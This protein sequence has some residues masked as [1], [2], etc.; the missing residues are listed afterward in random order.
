MGR[1]E[2]AG[3]VNNVKSNIHLST[4]TVALSNGTELLQNATMDTTAGHRYALCGRNCVGKSTLLH[5][6]AHRLIP[7]MPEMRII[8]VQQQVGGN[9]ETPVEV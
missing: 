9:Q 7:G 2:Y 1:G 6:V 3:K 8:L 4:V 5:R